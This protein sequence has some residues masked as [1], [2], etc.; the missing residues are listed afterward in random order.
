ME[1]LVRLYG[2]DEVAEQ[3]GVT[4]TTVLR[5]LRA[6]KLKGTKIARQWRVSETN[7][8]AFMN[9]DTY[10]PAQDKQRT[11]KG[12]TN[13]GDRLKAWAERRK[14][15][16]AAQK[17]EQGE[18]RRGRNLPTAY[19]GNDGKMHPFKPAASAGNGG[20]DD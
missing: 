13:N 6:G 11:N 20:A 18:A 2:V 1:Q 12:R 16:L 5:Y 10:D 3:L 7:L 8:L 14:A 4:P 19:M 15:A 9:G 17:A